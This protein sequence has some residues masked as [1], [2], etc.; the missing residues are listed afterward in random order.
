MYANQIDNMLSRKTNK[1]YL[2][3]TRIYCTRK[4]C[5]LSFGKSDPWS[6]S[7]LERLPPF[8]LRH[9]IAEVAIEQVVP[10]PGRQRWGRSLV[11]RGRG[12]LWRRRLRFL[13]HI[14]RWED[15]A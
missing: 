14:G 8:D 4:R 10:R 15:V 9:A 5:D 2:Y 12:L 7:G 6:R 11:V 1:I 3:T 13:G